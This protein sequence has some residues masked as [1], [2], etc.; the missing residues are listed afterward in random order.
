MVG[1]KIDISYAG[2]NNE[3][4]IID[5]RGYID[6]TTAPEFSK[7][8]E[9]QLGLKKYKF[10][11][12][13]KGIDYISSTGWGIFVTNLKELRGNQGDL[14]LVNMVPGVRNI[15]ELMEFSS[16]IKG[17]DSLEEAREYF[18]RE[19]V[20]GETTGG[21]KEG[22]GTV[23]AKASRAPDRRV[24]NLE[25]SKQSPVRGKTEGVN[26]VKRLRDKEQIVGTFKGSKIKVYYPNYKKLSVNSTDL[27]EITIL[28]T[29]RNELGQRILQVMFDHPKY[30]IWEISNA[31]QLPEYGSKKVRTY[32]VIEELI[33][34]D[35]LPKKK[36]YDFV[37]KKRK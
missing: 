22:S 17:F 28:S 36:R 20:A 11:I 1:I 18:L 6:T 33:R 26:I 14:V 5:A 19:K 13:L 24:E 31:L 10:I 2:K 30:E 32:V 7:Q 9:I 27:D 23:Q 37:S 8:L 35:L 3:V 16:I 21:F 12:N 29:A 25:T 4:V 34:M 15:F